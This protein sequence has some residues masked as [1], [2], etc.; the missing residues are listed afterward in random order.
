M[1]KVKIGVNGYG[2][3]GKR[4]A[5]AVAIQ[6]DMEVIGVAKRKPDFSA[7]FAINKG[8]ALY[9][10]SKENEK[11][12][13]D[14]GIEVGGLVEDLVNEVDL[15]VD[16]TPGGIGAKNKPMYE[17]AGIKAIFQG[18]EEHEV[19]GFSFN[20]LCNYDGAIGRDFVRVVSC[21]TTGLCRSLYAIEKVV[22]IDKVKAVMVRRATDPW[23]S[24]KGPINAIV[25]VLH[26]PSHHGPDVQTVMPHINI[27][28]MAV[29]VPTTIMHLHCVM[30]DIK[31][32]VGEEEIIEA[33][34]RTPRII[35][36]DGKSGITSTSQ[37]HE[38]SR[39][40]GRP[41]YDLYEIPIWRD[42]VHIKD[43]TIYFYQAVHQ[44]SDVV[45]ENIDAIRAMLEIEKDGKKSIEKTDRSMGII[46]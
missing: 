20:A 23:D 34:E 3:I 30:V 2:T 11:L 22:E 35:L 15:I 38:F 19:A 4:V 9:A 43:D 39:D 42:S 40:L 27:S 16:C 21:N 17:K 25:P 1:A 31:G 10:D 45:P 14:A 28:T 18:G 44:E 7:R 29:A 12:F 6:D 46:S 33:F 37:I 24:K 36:V 41:R 5:D 13:K 32:K 8:Y 26:V